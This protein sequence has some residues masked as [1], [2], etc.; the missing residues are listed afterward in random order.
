MWTGNLDQSR[1]AS[2]G[3]GKLLTRLYNLH[4]LMEDCGLISSDQSKK[5]KKNAVGEE[6]DQGMYWYMLK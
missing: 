6:N 5:T 2:G 1:E 4:K 3:R